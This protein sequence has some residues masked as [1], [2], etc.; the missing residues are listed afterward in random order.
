[1]KAEQ[2]LEQLAQSNIERIDPT[3]HSSPSDSCTLYGQI[4][5]NVITTKYMAQTE[6]FEEPISYNSDAQDLSTKLDTPLPGLS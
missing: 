1:M 4:G 3:S 6:H 5:Q 2:L